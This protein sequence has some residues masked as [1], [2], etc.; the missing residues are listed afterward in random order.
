MYIW[1]LLR[2]GTRYPSS[3]EIEKLLAGVPEL[4]K[5]LRANKDEGRVGEACNKTVDRVLD[6]KLEATPD[7]GDT[8][9]ER[10][11]QDL[12]GIGKRL[13]Q[14]HPTFFENYPNAA[15]FTV[16]CG[17]QPCLYLPSVFKTL[18]FSER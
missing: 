11:E 10:G 2:H 18:F 16:R 14:R 5:R 6:W 8:L 12:R 3:K 7:Q 1:H 13:K 4:Q 17:S 15:S 9:H